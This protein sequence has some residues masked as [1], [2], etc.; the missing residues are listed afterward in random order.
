[1]IHGLIK[2]QQKSVCAFP[3]VCIIEEESMID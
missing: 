1:M 3:V 2:L